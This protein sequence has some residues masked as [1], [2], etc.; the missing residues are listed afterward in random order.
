MN[1]TPIKPGIE[2]IKNCQ[3]THQSSPLE[4]KLESALL[5]FDETP[6]W[7][8]EAYEHRIKFPSFLI[9]QKPWSML[10]CWDASVVI[11]L[12]HGINA[13]SYTTIAPSED[14]ERIPELYIPRMLQE[15]Y[16]MKDNAVPKAIVVSGDLEHATRIMNCLSYHNIPLASSYFSFPYVRKEIYSNPKTGEIL[17]YSNKTKEATQLTVKRLK[18]V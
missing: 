11:L 12:D 6:R 14:P 5:A 17:V 8:Q 3:F 18:I 15:L 2:L 16:K 9:A 13:V 4:A 1:I 7:M 10:D